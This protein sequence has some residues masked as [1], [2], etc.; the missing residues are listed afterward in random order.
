MRYLRVATIALA[1]ALGG[2]K[3][4]RAPINPPQLVSDQE[5]DMAVQLFMQATILLARYYGYQTLDYEIIREKSARAGFSALPFMP[6]ETVPA[7]PAFRHGTMKP[8]IPRMEGDSAYKAMGA[9]QKMIETHIGYN[10]LVKYYVSTGLRGSQIICR[11]YLQNLEERNRYLE[12]L[13]AEFGVFRDTASLV[14]T[15]VGANGALRDGIA[16]GSTL[17]NQTI[18]KYQ[19]YRF[20]TVNYEEARVV[21]E[22]AQNLL[23]DHY[24]KKIDG[25]QPPRTVDGRIIYKTIFTFSDAL[26]AVSVIENQCTRAGIRRLLAKAV[27]ATPTNMVVDPATGSI[28]FLSNNVGTSNA[29]LPPGGSNAANAAGEKGGKPAIS[30]VGAATGAVTDADSPPV[31]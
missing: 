21:V 15:A 18:D 7:T 25:T 16:L 5:T 27:F 14:L 11:N 24:Y 26:S 13:Q 6:P 1:I 31:R 19:D 9:Y 28:G 20:L 2:C 22:A 8:F 3:S 17:V 12:F 23:A 10:N 29:L 4:A 30:G